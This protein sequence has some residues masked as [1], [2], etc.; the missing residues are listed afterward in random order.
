MYPQSRPAAAAAPRILMLA[1]LVLV[2]APSTIGQA[3]ADP[4]E[5]IDV[6]DA[7]LAQAIK[8][9]LGLTKDAELTCGALAKLREL[10]ARDAGI[11]SLSGLERATELERLDCG[12]NLIADLTPLSALKRLG[13]LRVERNLVADLGPL[14]KNAQ[15]GQG[16]RLNVTLNCLELSAGS[17]DQ[18]AVD[19]LVKR[20]VDI[21]FRTQKDR[22]DCAKKHE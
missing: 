6:E 17:E 18:Q 11:V 9:Q 8:R 19:T 1:A 4:Q 15:L 22:A 20:G 7:A 12:R 14:L 13:E 5:V 21:E 3:C 2:S 10:G 16:F